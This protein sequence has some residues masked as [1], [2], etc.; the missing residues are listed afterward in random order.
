MRFQRHRS[1]AVLVCGVESGVVGVKLVPI[2]AAVDSDRICFQ[3][4]AFRKALLVDHFAGN[5]PDEFIHHGDS[6]N[7][8]VVA[9]KSLR[10]YEDF[11]AFGRNPVRPVRGVV[12]VI[13]RSAAARKNSVIG[14]GKERGRKKCRI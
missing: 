3:R 12:P 14:L 1:G 8:E 2:V 13:V 7:R 11:G 4:P 6:G 9:G 10:F 5:I